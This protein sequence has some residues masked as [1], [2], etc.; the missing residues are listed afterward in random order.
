MS[1][2]FLKAVEVWRRDGP[3]HDDDQYDYAER[4]ILKRK[5]QSATEAAI[6]L[7][8]VAVNL[9]VGPRSDE[10]D[11][12]AIKAVSCWLHTKDQVAPRSRFRMAG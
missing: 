8:V 6:I 10:L 2:A 5:P 3:W 7:E 9:A 11:I 1:T 4:V 12:K